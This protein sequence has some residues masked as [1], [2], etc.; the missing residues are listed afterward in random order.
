M[1]LVGVPLLA[2]AGAQPPP[3][4]PA[5]PAGTPAPVHVP[6][7]AGTTPGTAFDALVALMRIL[8]GPTGCPWDREQTLDTLP[9]NLERIHK[10]RADAGREGPFQVTLGARVESLDDG[11]GITN[12]DLYNTA[13]KQKLEL[14]RG[15]FVIVRT[16][17]MERCQKAGSWDGYPGG[18]A[19]VFSFETLDFVK[20]T[21]LAAL[22]SDTWGCEVR[23]NESEEGINQPWH[24]ITIPI[25]GMTM[26]E[27]FNVRELAEDCAAD[28]VYE[29]L[30]VAP[31]IPITGAVGSPVN[32]LAIK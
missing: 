22:A 16:G 14:K 10:V 31:A 25:M 11:Y 28:G 26:G 6:P 3:A 32:P 17:M 2:A 23:P 9:G 21:Q 18:D 12:D 24:W 13:K 1:A 20:D 5:A 8:R 4:E 15:D 19:P 27:I 29:Y 30:F 7:P